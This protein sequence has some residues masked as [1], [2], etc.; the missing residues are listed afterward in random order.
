[1]ARGPPH[2]GARSQE[3]QG[4]GEVVGR[5]LGA[6]VVVAEHPPRSGERVLAELP[7]CLDLT[8]RMEGGGEW[9][10][11]TSVEVHSCVVYRISLKYAGENSAT[12]R[13]AASTARCIL[14]TKFSPAAPSQQSNSTVYPAS[15]KCQ[16]THS[17]HA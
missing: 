15:T 7:R 12:I 1:M 4:G 5:F 6:R 16:A 2:L 14:V 10:S 11:V 9:A 3:S 13:F 8:H 17:A